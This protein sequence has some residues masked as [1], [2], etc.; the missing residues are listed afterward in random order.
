MTSSDSD[1]DSDSD[2][3]L[4][5][6]EEERTL[7]SP[8]PIPFSLWDTFKPHL[9]SFL[10]TILV[11][12]V[13]P[14]VI[15]LILHKHVKPVHA[16]L[17]AGI[18][19]FLMIIIKASLSRTFDALGFIVL[20]AFVASALAAM[21]THNPTVILLEKSLITGMISFIFG[22]T[23]IPC[24]CCQ[25]RVRPLAFY[26]Y[27][28]FVPTSRK[29]IGL[30]DFIFDGND[31]EQNEHIRSDVSRK[32]EIAQVYEW[33]Y[34]H[35]KSFRFSC[36]VITSIWFVGLLLE[37]LAR[38]TLILIHLSVEKIFIYGHLILTVMTIILVI[39]TILS[40]VKERQQ[41][42][43]M[44]TQ[45]KHEHLDSYRYQLAIDI[46]HSSVSI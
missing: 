41:T 13:V 43:I 5:L 23:L 26:F 19:P 35:C 36:Y 11:D 32:K 10:L 12:V 38:F 24:S 21:I 7:S 15:Y 3:P 9:P 18:P 4:L 46:D 45:W 31:A 16:L 2:C 33:I 37:F 27:Q 17:A 44:I 1:S 20:I 6:L 34:T 28:D 22:I 14:M 30:P 29:Q 40:I 42:L 39:L 25:Y 8:S